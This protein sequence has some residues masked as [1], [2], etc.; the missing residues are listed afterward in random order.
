[1][2]EKLIAAA[3]ERALNPPAPP[4]S[5][6]PSIGAEI[7]RALPSLAQCVTGIMENWGRIAAAKRDIASLRVAQPG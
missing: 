6:G 7:E 1:M 5:S 4:A 2:E 3:V